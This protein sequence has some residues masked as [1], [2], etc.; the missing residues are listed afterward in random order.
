[1][2]SYLYPWGWTHTLQIASDLQIEC[3]YKTT[4]H[5]PSHKFRS[6][7]K[8]LSHISLSTVILNSRDRHE[9]HAIP[10]LRALITCLTMYFTQKDQLKYFGNTIITLYLC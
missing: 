9:K 10:L 8:P 4:F 3:N 7:F 6:I 2:N 5:K 1:M